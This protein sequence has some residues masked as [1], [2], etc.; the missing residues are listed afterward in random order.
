MSAPI[1]LLSP[2]APVKDQLVV[3]DVGVMLIKPFDPENEI[4]T[5]IALLTSRLIGGWN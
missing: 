1:P 2:W 3:L 4:E 5:T